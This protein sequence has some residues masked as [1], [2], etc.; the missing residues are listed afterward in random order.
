MCIKVD[1]VG[2]SKERWHQ[3]KSKSDGFVLRC[4]LHGYTQEDT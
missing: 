2:S 4:T 1:S 3:E